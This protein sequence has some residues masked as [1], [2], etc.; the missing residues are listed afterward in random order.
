MNIIEKS[1]HK[2]DHFQQRHVPLAF[3]VAVIKKY[4]DDR[5]GYQAA[6]LT[7]YTFLAL[8]PLLLILTT[9]TSLIASS[10]PHLQ[11][12]LIRGVTS[13]FPILGGQLSSH[14]HT[15]HRN[16]LALVIGLLVLFYG[17][18]G[19][20]DI[21]RFMVNE[22]WQIPLSKRDGFPKSLIKSLALIIVGGAGFTLASISAGLAASAGHGLLFRLLSL[23]VNV[24]LLY[25]LF[26]FLINASLPRQVPLRETQTGA[27]AAAIGLVILQL[28]GTYIL[29]H[30]LKN[31]DAL[32]SYFALALG[33]L[34]WIYL[35]AQ[36]LCYAMEIAT[37]QAEKL[38]PRRLI[39]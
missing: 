26:S 2:F 9:L 13:Y 8:F 22:I 24:F 10:H 23:A 4:G 3:T 38:W 21:F 17:A 14:V 39:Q 25:W 20:A 1:L 35:Q 16:G 29:R 32:Y 7:Y 36:V 5:A 30:T 28:L 31:L 18:R 15:L 37:V 33:L 12:T 27:A 34:F 6:L 19:I 11:A